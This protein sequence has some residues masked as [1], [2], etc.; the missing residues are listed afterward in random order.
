M[1][2][3]GAALLVFSG[4]FPA[5]IDQP[6]TPSRALIGDSGAPWFFLWIQET[7]KLG[8]PFF[9]GVVVPLLAV[10]IL[11]LLPYVL[12]HAEPNEQG[13]WLPKGNR[14]AQVIGMAVITILFGLTILGW[15]S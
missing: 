15:V 8:N 2:I 7:L 13:H 5:P 1:L 12:P 14:A 3:G 10:I 11:G 6:L 4:I 9:W